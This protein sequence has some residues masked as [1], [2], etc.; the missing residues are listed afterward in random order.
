MRLIVQYSIVPKRS[1]NCLQM[2]S[3]SASRTFWKITCLACMA[4]MRPNLA[5][6]T[7]KRTSSPI[8]ADGLTRRAWDRLT[9]NVGLATKSVTVLTA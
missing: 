4:A 2:V 6:G 9:S 1:S 5:V 7:A 8:L 3:R